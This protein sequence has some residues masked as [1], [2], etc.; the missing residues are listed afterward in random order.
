MQ[1]NEIKW[2]H[3][4]SECST[5]RTEVMVESCIENIRKR[6]LE[7]RKNVKKM[8]KNSD[9]ASNCRSSDN[10]GARLAPKIPVSESEID[11]RIDRI[12]SF[13]NSDNDDSEVD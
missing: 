3:L 12:F 8:C 10:E 7:Y 1:D 2:D 9:R 5:A 6:D 11:K 4:Q 13:V